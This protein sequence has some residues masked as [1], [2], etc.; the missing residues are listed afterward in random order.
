[1]R[2]TCKEKIDRDSRGQEHP[3]GVVKWYAEVFDQENE[4]V[5]MATI[6]TLVQKKCPFVEMNRDT[7]VKCINGLTEN[8]R[9]AWGIMT[10]QHLVEHFEFF[11]RMTTGEVQTE[12]ITSE[13]N[14]EKYQDSLWT[15][16]DMAKNYQHP[17]FKKDKT[18]KLR[19]DNLDDAKNAL[20][21]AYDNYIQFFKENP[22]AKTA[23]TIFG[24]L[25]K[26]HW[27]L[28]NRRHMNHHFRQF[29]VLNS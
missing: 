12:I 15:F 1:M 25:D 27:H 29:G 18:E 3:S 6:L 13:K 19:F 28:L 11:F 2:L 23:N 14:I 5:A 17:L 8:T 22:N 26:Y 21:L 20:F 4:L 16:E 24:M 9:P 10:P 7:I